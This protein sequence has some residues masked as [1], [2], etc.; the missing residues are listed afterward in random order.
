MGICTV[1]FLSYRKDKEVWWKPFC[2]RRIC[3]GRAA[4]WDASEKKSCSSVIVFLV[5]SLVESCPGLFRRDLTWIGIEHF[6]QWKGSTDIYRGEFGRDF[7]QWNMAHGMAR[8]NSGGRPRAPRTS[9][10]KPRCRPNR[11][12]KI[13]TKWN[14]SGRCDLMWFACHSDVKVFSIFRNRV[15]MIMLMMW[16]QGRQHP[17]RK[18]NIR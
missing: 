12:R 10:R 18:M 6:Y 15:E 3:L 5:W 11:C 7:Y 16:L 1:G 4:A 13:W 9:P 14:R 17:S 8:R 2:N